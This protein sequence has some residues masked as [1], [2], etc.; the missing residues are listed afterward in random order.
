MDTSKRI[1]PDRWTCSRAMNMMLL[2][3]ESHQTSVEDALTVGKVTLPPSQMPQRCRW[4]PSKERWGKW[5][6]QQEWRCPRGDDFIRNV[7]LK[8]F[9]E[10]FLTSEADPNSE[11]WQ[12]WAWQSMLTPFISSGMKWVKAGLDYANCSRETY[13]ERKSSSIWL[14]CQFKYVWVTAFISLYIYNQQQKL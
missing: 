14:C 12:F 9:S 5:P 4:K 2:K 6:C 10:I 1:G 3:W 13:K 7:P 11:E 8:E